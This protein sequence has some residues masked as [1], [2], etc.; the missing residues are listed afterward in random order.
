MR[1]AFVVQ[2]YGLDIAG[3]A[4]Y[5]CR[6]IAEH[7]ARHASVSVTVLTTCAS[8]Y[9]TWANR[10]P[11]GEEAVNGVPVRRFAVER[12]RDPEQ[13]AA[14]TARV[15]GEVAR[16]EPGRFD[17]EVVARASSAEAL[18]W[19]DAQGPLCPRLLAH[20]AQEQD[21]YDFVIFFSYRYWIT[22][23]GVH[24]LPD[25]AV[26]VPTAEDDGVY[27][28]PIFPPLFR[29]PRA[30][31]YNSIEER[32]MIERV[33]GNRGLPAAV[34][35]VG[36]EVPERVDGEGFRARH[37]LDGP[38]LLYVGRIDLNKGCPQLFEFFLRYRRETGSSLRLVLIGRSVLE[39]PVDAG[40]VPLGFQPDA[41]KWNALAA[42]TAFVLPSAMES[43]SIATLEAWW[44]ERPALVNAK[45]AVLRGQCKRSNAGLY[46]A[47]YEEFREALALLEKDAPLRRRLGRNGRRYFE[48]NYAWPVVEGK[49]LDLLGRLRREDVAGPRAA[50]AERFP[51]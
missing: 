37:G 38:F 22:W 1:L 34:V 4:E 41:E 20:L 17:P 26:L 31:V 40:I 43:L 13:F 18:A 36:S 3:G 28:L 5:E 12:P 15:L 32:E 29:A 51:G 16:V 14:H 11:E 6:L 33:S 7:L 2:R 30:L 35:G 27:R 48:A 23:H 19:L 8:D 46:Y 25:H 9:V 21:A 50:G 49:V 47:S 44:S 42:C 45:C 39:V 10:Y 24:A